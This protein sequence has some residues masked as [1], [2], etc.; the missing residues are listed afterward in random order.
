MTQPQRATPRRSRD[1]WHVYTGAG[2]SKRDI[3]QPESEADAALIVYAVNHIE[4]AEAQAAAL[5]DLVKAYDSGDKLA[6]KFEQ[7]RAA[8][9]AK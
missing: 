8:L 9:E 5:N 7:A 6:E 2:M 3:V 4:A 1:G